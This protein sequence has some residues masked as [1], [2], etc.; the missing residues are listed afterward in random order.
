MYFATEE[1]KLSNADMVEMLR[2]F[3]DQKQASMNKV[4]NDYFTAQ[5]RITELEDE[6]KRL[7]EELSKYGSC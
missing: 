4:L 3:L 6:N 5:K 2:N 7:R 1:K